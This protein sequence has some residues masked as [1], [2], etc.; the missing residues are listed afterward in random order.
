MDQRAFDL[1]PARSTVSR[2]VVAVCVLLDKAIPRRVNVGDFCTCEK[3]ALQPSD[4][5][6]I[7]CRETFES[8]CVYS[9]TMSAFIG[10][11]KCIC[12]V[13]SVRE[14]VLHEFHLNLFHQHAMYLKQLYGGNGNRRIPPSD[15]KR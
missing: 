4:R 3:C 8:S 15:P 6:S 12:D 14:V 10:S 7:C 2:P 13:P 9:N 5:E 1:Y 11:Y